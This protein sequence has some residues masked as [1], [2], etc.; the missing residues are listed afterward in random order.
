VHDVKIGPRQKI[1]PTRSVVLEGPAASGPGAS[2]VATFRVVRWLWIAMSLVYSVVYFKT[3]ILA[4]QFIR[5]L[6]FASF[7]VLQAVLISAY[8]AS[9]NFRSRAEATIGSAAAALAFAGIVEDAYFLTKGFFGGARWDWDYG[10]LVPGYVWT[11]LMVAGLTA[12]IALG[13]LRSQVVQAENRA[14][15]ALAADWW[16]TY[17]RSAAL[18]IAIQA[19]CF[20]LFELPRRLFPP[21]STHAFFSIGGCFLI[22]TIPL[23]LKP[24]NRSRWLLLVPYS[25]FLALAIVVGFILLVVYTMVAQVPGG[26]F[27]WALFPFSLV[28]VWIYCFP[29]VPLYLWSTPAAIPLSATASPPESI[30]WPALSTIVALSAVGLLA[31]LPA[32]LF[33]T[34]PSSLGLHGVGCV[35]AISSQPSEYWFWKGYKGVSH[36]VLNEDPIIFRPAVSPSFCIVIPQQKLDDRAAM[37]EGYVLAARSW[38]W[39]IDPEQWDSERTNQI[40]ANLA[41]LIGHDFSSYD[42]L[43]AWWEENNQ[44]LTWS[45]EDQVLEIQK[46]DWQIAHPNAW[47]LPPKLSVVEQL[48]R[49][50]PR[51]LD[52]PASQFTPPG[53]PELQFG[54][55]VV[56]LEARL[57]GLKLYVADGVD[58]LTGE[59]QR[60]IHDYLVS[61]TGKDYATPEEWMQALNQ[62]RPNDARFTAWQNATAMVMDLCQEDHGSF[63]CPGQTLKTLKL[64]TGNTFDSPQQWEQW[65]HDNRATIALSE[66][67]RTLVSK[68]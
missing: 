12:G 13:I 45:A 37:Q 9:R 43:S 23:V 68:K 34:S 25:G 64:L 4:G 44:Y 67:G 60:R 11:V 38:F 47:T 26:I 14:P 54:S 46:T 40:R 57:R 17:I 6:L 48:R 50:G 61:L 36:E 59:R 29:W 58:I 49:D 55:A 15:N 3:A 65:W 28:L 19:V 16:S 35:M 20:W 41:H 22:A 24:G 18:W 2:S 52:D 56:D 27:L 8:V 51:W 1:F 62:P 53:P 10:V 66:D 31:A 30:A 39:L 32:G 5:G 33:A 42:E 7:P 63:H 21:D